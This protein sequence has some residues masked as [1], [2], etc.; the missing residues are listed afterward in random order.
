VSNITCLTCYIVKISSPL[1]DDSSNTS[2]EMYDISKKTVSPKVVSP[3]PDEA[4]PLFAS[5]PFGSPKLSLPFISCVWCAQTPYFPSK[6]LMRSLRPHTL[7]APSCC[8]RPLIFSS[9]GL[10]P[11]VTNC[12]HPPALPDTLSPLA[13]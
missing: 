8:I 7:P 10:L 3:R 9:I 13:T 5:H 1:L 4:S 11:T 2:G 6:C 12:A